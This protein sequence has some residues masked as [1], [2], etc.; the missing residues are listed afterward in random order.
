MDAKDKALQV[1]QGAS[2]LKALRAQRSRLEEEIAHA[3]EQL[4]AYE[5][6]Q[7]FQSQQV[8]VL[9]R[10]LGEFVIEQGR[11]ALLLSKAQQKKVVLDQKRDMLSEICDSFDGVFDPAQA[12]FFTQS[13]SAF[14]HEHALGEMSLGD[15]VKNSGDGFMLELKGE[16]YCFLNGSE[17]SVWFHPEPFPFVELLDEV[18]SDL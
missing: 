4:L 15:L 8:N 5:V 13:L 10:Q 6:D 16:T 3:D 14:A 12:I 11:T 2:L 1:L 7:E 18:A 17:G 9:E